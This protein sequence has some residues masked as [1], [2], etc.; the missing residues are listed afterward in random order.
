MTSK[1][2]LGEAQRRMRAWWNGEVLDRVALAVYARR[3]TPREEPFDAPD[4]CTVEGRWLDPDHRIARW[5]REFVYTDFLGEAIP[6]FSS[7]IGPGS[8]GIFLGARPVFHPTTVWYE[9]AIEDLCSAEALRFDPQNRWYQAHLR[10]IEAGLERGK[11]RYYTAM[12]DLIEGLDTL[13]AL[14]GNARLLTDLLDHQHEVHRFLEQITALYFDAYDP[15]YDLVKGPEG[16]CCFAGFQTWAP[17]RYAKVQCDFCAMISPEMFAEFVQPYLAK[18]CERLD[19]AMYHLDGPDCI[20]HLDLLLEIPGIQVI[21]WTPGAGQEPTCSPRWY[22]MYRKILSKGR[23]V[24]IMGVP[25]GQVEGVVRAL[26]PRGVYITTW[27]NS[28]DEG[29]RLLKAARTW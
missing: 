29:E 5:E 15:I 9:P 21:Q 13:A 26:G 25:P 14:H 20:R 7:Q 10:L 2:D 19:Y 3:R 24:I 1:E 6:C 16:G 18:Q 8:L 17:G 4:P 12:P 22:D 27:V 23:S 28:R 11:G